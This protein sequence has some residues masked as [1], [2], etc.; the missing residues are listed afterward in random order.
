MTEQDVH[1]F[2]KRLYLVD[3]LVAQPI[4]DDFG[5]NRN[6][7]YGTA[8][9]M[10]R[11]RPDAQVLMIPNMFFTGYAPDAYC[12]TYRKKFLQSPMPIH[13]VNFIYSYLRHTGERDLVSADYVKKLTEPDFYDP[14][15]IRGHVDKNIAALETREAN[16]REKF[17]GANVRFFSYSKFVAAWYDKTLLHYSDAHPT[18]FVFD[19]VARGILNHLGL[20]NDLRPVVVHEKGA[21]PFYRSIDVAL[22]IDASATPIF[23]NDR[24]V[25]FD[26]Y[27]SQYCEEYDGIGTRELFGYVAGNVTKVVVTNHKTGTM[28]MAGI[29]REYCARYG[30][31]YMDLS[32]HLAA[33]NA[34]LGINVDTV[35][36]ALDFQSYDFIFVPHAQHFEILVD[37]VPNLRYRAV[38]LTRNPYE[39]IMLGV[40]FHQITDEQWCN[41]KLFVADARGPCGFRRIA[42]YDVGE[43]GEVGDHSYREIM[44]RLPDDEKIEFEIRNH[45]STFSTILYIESFLKRFQGDGNITSV[46][47]GGYRNRG[48]C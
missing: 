27:F 24:E 35:D 9:I 37:A 36:P 5:G 13:D 31:R 39:I 29:L 11:I 41:K 1:E 47:V 12:V 48:M 40:R 8:G 21:L 18:E 26:E 42:E 45:T 10:R 30:L 38:H 43:D 6:G 17:K 34:R 44:N 7:L 4:G 2:H 32:D 20:E 3:H 22:G 15:F 25:T 14:K 23:L 16:S 28:L 46:Q 19:K 33:N